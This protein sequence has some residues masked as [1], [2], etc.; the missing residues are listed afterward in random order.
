MVIKLGNKKGEITTSK[1]VTIILLVLGFG[2][3][4]YFWFTVN[5][6]NLTDE[7]IC[8]NSVIQKATGQGIVGK[9]DC[10]T[11]YVC[12][13]G[14]GECEGINPSDTIKLDLDF[15]YA[16]AEEQIMKAVADEM[17]TCW[18]MFGEGQVSYFDFNQVGVLGQTACAACSIVKFDEEITKRFITETSQGD[19]YDYLARTPKDDTHTYFSYLYPADTP[20]EIKNRENHFGFDDGSY[21]IITGLK[22]P[23]LGGEALPLTT[24]FGHVDDVTSSYECDFFVTKST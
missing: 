5:L 12:I 18:W 4:L 24:Y 1:I 10:R 8:H 22:K 2:I 17:A 14:G 19:F 7:Q 21:I 16:V 20:K 23:L 13:S 6:G 11:Q 15:S 9:L 3:A